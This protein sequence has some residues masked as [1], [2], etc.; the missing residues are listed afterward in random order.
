MGTKIATF[1]SVRWLP[2]IF[3]DVARHLNKIIMITE[4][5]IHYM[6]II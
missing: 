1:I 5:G 2:H 4:Q 3:A 6:L